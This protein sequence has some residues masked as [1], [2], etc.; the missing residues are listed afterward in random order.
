[1]RRHKIQMRYSLKDC[2]YHA[3]KD[4]SSKRTNELKSLHKQFPTRS[5]KDDRLS[6]CSN[7]PERPSS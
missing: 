5:E 4:Q 7:F 6:S 1:M 3:N 2:P